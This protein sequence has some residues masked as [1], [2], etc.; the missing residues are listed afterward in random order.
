ML[1]SVTSLANQIITLICGFILPKLILSTFGSN[2]NG[3]VTSINQF[4]NVI[5]FLDLGVGAVVT[6]A[7]YR[8]LAMKDNNEIG[9]IYLSAKS[10]F[11]RIAIIFLGYI[12]VLV[13]KINRY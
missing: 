6:S 1:N 10:F 11:N 5:T 7:L 3:L 8:P 13:E 2:V 4:L 9:Q 12:A